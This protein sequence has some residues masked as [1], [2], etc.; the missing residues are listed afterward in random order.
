MQNL[1]ANVIE[2]LSAYRAQLEAIA[3]IQEKTLAMKTETAAVQSQLAGLREATSGHSLTQYRT[4]KALEER[5]FVQQKTLAELELEIPKAQ[6]L[7]NSYGAA[8]TET[9][10]R[11]DTLEADV[12]QFRQRIKGGEA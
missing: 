4:V 2:G 11:H 3:A 9:K 8:N 10:H 5:I 12:L 1:V 6:A 7:L